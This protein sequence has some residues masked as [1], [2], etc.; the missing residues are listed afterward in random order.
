LL[1]D[2]LGD[3]GPVQ[4]GA[5]RR[6]RFGDLVDGVPGRAQLND[7][8]AGGV[9]G[10]GGLRAGPAGDE[11]LPRAGAEV[12]DR[13][14]QAGGGVAEPGGGLVGGQ[15]LGEVG[16]QRLIPAVRRGVRAE[17]ELSAGPGGLRG[18]R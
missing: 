18:I 3:P 11:E 5:L 8:R 13:R 12:P 17:E 14:Q 16:A 6:E 4:T 1:G 7:P 15:A 10:R 9:L 2:H